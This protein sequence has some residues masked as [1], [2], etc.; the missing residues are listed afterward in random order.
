MKCA[1][2]CMVTPFGAKVEEH[3]I[4]EEDCK[5][6]AFCVRQMEGEPMGLF[7]T[8]V[9]ETVMM[10]VKLRAMAA[11]EAISN[12]HLENFMYPW[13]VRGDCDKSLPDNG[14]PYTHPNATIEDVRKDA[15]RS[16][17]ETGKAISDHSKMEFKGI[18]R[19]Q[20]NLN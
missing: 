4:G 3:D 12:P 8:R 13:P 18:K 9:M 20:G 16:S 15:E 19:R 10:V 5:P 11:G 7:R 17:M 6:H 2:V 1:D 14:T